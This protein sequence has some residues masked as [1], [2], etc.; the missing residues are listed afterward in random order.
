MKNYELEQFESIGQEYAGRL[1]S[2]GIHSVEDFFLHSL[3]EI[4]KFTKVGRKRVEQWRDCLDLFRIPKISPREAE[5]LYH[6][7]VNSVKELS[8]RQAVRI[9]YKL[10]EID[11]AT[12]LII[13][14]LPTFRVI[15]EWIYYAKLLTMRIKTGLN[16]P[17][18]KLPVV[19]VEAAR[20]FEKYQVFTVEELLV[21]TPLV[22]SLRKKVGMSK[23]EWSG[24]LGAVSLLEV[25]GIDVYF[26]DIL[27]RAGIHDSAALSSKPTAE[28]VSRA[29]EVQE[30][31]LK[32]PEV[33]TTELVEMWKVKVAGGEAP[34][35]AAGSQTGEVTP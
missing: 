8:H 34:R 27:A 9:Y 24:L 16:V 10:K 21:K 33:V 17:L 15:D 30:N 35:P 19:T 7:N 1:A 13:I 2:A 18:V 3:D 23:V 11:E 20:E 32:V 6:A 25:D 22:K 28:V 29:R 14:D 31:D 5:L 26:A 4:E 12:Y